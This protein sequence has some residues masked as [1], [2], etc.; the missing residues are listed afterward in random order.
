MGLPVLLWGPLDTE[1][2]E[3]GL[4]YTDSQCGLFAI[5]KQF[6]RYNIPFSY[7]ENCRIEDD[8]FEKGM[9]KFLAV[10]TMVKNFKNL[11]ITQVGS[12]LN[13]FKSVMANELELTEKFGFNLQTVNMAQFTD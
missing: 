5:S 7:I 13:P 6:K 1:Y 3:K 10:A 11:K 9:E 4:R 8:V 2:G 12:R